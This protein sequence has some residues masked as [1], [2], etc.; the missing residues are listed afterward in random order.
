MFVN[1]NDLKIISMWL[2]DSIDFVVLDRKKKS[3]TKH[4]NRETFF[5]EKSHGAAVVF[6]WST[7][8]GQRELTCFVFPADVPLV[9]PPQNCLRESV[10]LSY[11]TATKI[12]ANLFFWGRVNGKASQAKAYSISLR[13]YTSLLK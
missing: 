6:R 9:L 1:T 3:K 2:S 4:K 5:E 12:Y 8:N 10:C 7:P 11:A 13:S